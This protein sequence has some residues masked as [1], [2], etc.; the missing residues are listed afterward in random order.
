MYVNKILYS[1][2]FNLKVSVSFSG[3]GA[4]HPKMFHEIY[5]NHIEA[6]SIFH[7]ASEIFEADIAKLC[8]EGSEEQLKITTNTQPCIITCDIAAWVVLQKYFQDIHYL[9]GFSLGECAALYAAGCLPIE[10]VFKIV[11]VRAA[12]MHEVASSNKG[13]M[14][15]VFCDDTNIINNA[16]KET[17]SRNI[18]ISNVNTRRQIVLSGI[19]TLRNG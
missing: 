15:A 8:F 3:Q 18:W 7:L 16:I 19:E 9:S 14:I 17:N 1:V 11:K 4:Q 13:A 5:E 12:L 2:V 10:D 6:R